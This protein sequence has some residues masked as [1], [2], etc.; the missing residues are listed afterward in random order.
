M[1]DHLAIDVDYLADWS[2]GRRQQ[3]SLYIPGST[4][5]EWVDAAARAVQAGASAPPGSGSQADPYVLGGYGSYAGAW[6][7]AA[8][9]RS[10]DLYFSIAG[11]LI[12]KIKDGSHGGFADGCYM[13]D[14]GYSGT[15]ARAGTI[16]NRADG[17]SYREFGKF[18]HEGNTVSGMEGVVWSQ[19]VAASLRGVLKGTAPRTGG[20]LQAKGTR[21]TVDMNP[22]ESKRKAPQKASAPQTAGAADTISALP[23]LSA[24]MFIAEPMR[25]ARAWMMGLMMLDLMGTE[26]QAPTPT[27][28]GKHFTFQRA[29]VHPSRLDDPAWRGETNT[30]NDTA[31]GAWVNRQARGDRRTATSMAR[32]GSAAVEGLYPPSPKWSGRSSARI[33]VA[34]DYIQAK[35]TAIVC[36]WLEQEF[37]AY[38]GSVVVAKALAGGP[39][40]R[41]NAMTASFG[42]E[43]AM[44]G[45]ADDLERVIK[46][47]L[48]QR[49]AASFDTPGVLF[50]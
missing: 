49:R 48:I 23:L 29:F 41:R 13:C 1:F 10:Q 25:N 15:D 9:R 46:M 5:L 24:V 26:Y 45:F 33:D 2:T 38:V 22:D 7:A 6:Q 17:A 16:W 42:G 37:N 19:R 43:S 39:G 31:P 44:R 14:V 11:R 3:H 50:R 20:G 32:P 12:R 18:I 47:E 27:A 21:W 35:E 34:N 36:R 40:T 28:H 8:S 4:L 30:A